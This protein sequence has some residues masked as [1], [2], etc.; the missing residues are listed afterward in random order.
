M[1]MVGAVTVRPTA[2][3]DAE[4]VRA[5]SGSSGCVA[6]KVRNAAAPAS[7]TGNVG[8]RPAL[9]DVTGPGVEGPALSDVKGPGV[10]GALDYIVAHEAATKR[11]SRDPCG[12]RCPS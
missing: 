12:H 4:N 2:K 3:V 9:S 11:F 6:Y 1:A 10:E 8:R 7:A 5:R